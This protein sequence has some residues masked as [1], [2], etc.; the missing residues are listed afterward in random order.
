[1]RRLAASFLAI[2][3]C[4]SAVVLAAP[5]SQAA[6][7]TTITMRVAGCEGCTVLSSSWTDKKGQPWDGPTAT[8]T[9]GV[10]TM[11][12]PTDR[13]RGMSFV[14]Q[15]TWKPSV[16]FETVIVTQYAGFAPGEKVVWG[17]AKKAKTASPCW[18][19]TSSS[20]VTVDVAVKKVPLQAFPPGTKPP[21][22][23]AAAA[24][25]VVTDKASGQSWQTEKG[26]LGAQDSILCAG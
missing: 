18:S 4:A 14:L 19:G 25:L 22:T 16:D 15:P 20:D 26:V 11:V 2:A 7:N 8:V 23:K 13:T 21:V 24:Y 9:N 6:P 3:S 12:V 10:A 1:M 5:A 17:Q